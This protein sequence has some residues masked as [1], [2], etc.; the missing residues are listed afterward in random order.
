MRFEE[1][2]GLYRGDG[3]AEVKEPLSMCSARQ[4][5]QAVSVS[6]PED[7]PENIRRVVDNRV[8]SSACDVED[9]SYAAGAA[10]W[11]SD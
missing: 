6:N 5:A 1:D 7:V 4:L 11:G 10:G 9:C 8:G 3:R 2:G